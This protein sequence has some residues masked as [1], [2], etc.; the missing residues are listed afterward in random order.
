M[1]SPQNALLTPDILL[2]HTL[3]TP[4]RGIYLRTFLSSRKGPSQIACRVEMT[5]PHFEPV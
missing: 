4:A 5:V 3:R 1:L 2:I